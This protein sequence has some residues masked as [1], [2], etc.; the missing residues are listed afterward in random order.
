MW[1]L[2]YHL[3]LGERSFESRVREGSGRLDVGDGGERRGTWEEQK[4]H[5]G[6]TGEG[7]APC[8]S[9][10]LHR[11]EPSRDSTDLASS[12]S[13]EP[14]PSPHHSLPPFPKLMPLILP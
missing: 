7:S 9:T 3:H 5:T 12:Q 2:V 6:E 1:H 13:G 11:A 10:A 8:L 4:A 14:C